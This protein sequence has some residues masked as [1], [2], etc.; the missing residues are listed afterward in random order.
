M[1]GQMTLEDF[2]VQINEPVKYAV[3]ERWRPIPGAKS[4]AYVSNFGRVMQNGIVIKPQVDQE[5]Y[6]RLTIAGIGRQRVHRLVADVWVGNPDDKPQVD[7]K[8]NNKRNNRCENLQWVTSQENT[9][10]AGRDGLIFK[11]NK[12][13]AVRAE[14]IFTGEIIDFPSQVDAGRELNINTKLISKVINGK[15]KSTHN[16]RFTKIER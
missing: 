16:Y 4:A 2:G 5:G 3:V 11:R 6:E 1:C 8:D 9:A 13:M 10:K 15:L 14:N 7:H 12:T